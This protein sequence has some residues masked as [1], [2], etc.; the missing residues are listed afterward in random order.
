MTDLQLVLA[1]C[2]I[3]DIQLDLSDLDVADIA[4]AKERLGLRG[5]FIERVGNIILNEALVEK[6]AAERDRHLDEE[7]ITEDHRPGAVTV[8]RLQRAAAKVAEA[9]AA[10]CGM[11]AEHA[12]QE[13]EY[14]KRAIA[15]RIGQEM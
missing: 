15:V 14:L 7:R 1:E 9:N 10:L 13:L 12:R 6:F 2:Q 5:Q 3:P 4:E 8:R 11:R